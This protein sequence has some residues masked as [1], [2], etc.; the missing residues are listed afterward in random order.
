MKIAIVGA[1][2]FVGQALS[3]EFEK[4][5]NNI[6]IKIDRRDTAQNDDFLIKKLEADVVINL[7]GTP[8]I[9]RWTDKYKKSLRSSRIDITQRLV[10]LFAKM[11]N[12]P[13]L[14]ISTSA[15]GIYDNQG[16]YSEK[17][18]NYSKDFLSQLC[19]D[20]ENEALKANDLNIRTVIFRF[21]IVLGKNG[22]ALQ[23]MLLPFK[24]GLGGKIGS[25]KQAFSFVHINDL[26][27]AYL[28]IIKNENLKAVFNLSAPEP[29]TNLGLTK[30]LGK[31]LHRPT[32]C[33]V[34][35][36]VLNLIYG[37]GAKVLTDGQTMIP[38]KLLDSGF[39][40]QFENIEKTINNIINL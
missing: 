1:N 27:N 8:I 37:E 23:K 21:G 30:A 3:Q 5:Q 14:F 31:A 10:K 6:I 39:K 34:P 12:K 18:Q 32:I 33:P 38:Q 16:I 25:G 11:S 28:F 29:T 13:K 40:F 2:G 9:G 22:G 19:I 7:A 15:V 35:E 26:I 4:D 24:L 17:D 20:W 36:F